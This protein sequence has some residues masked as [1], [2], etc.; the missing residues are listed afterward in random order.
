M[1]VQSILTI[2]LENI[3]G[4]PVRSIENQLH[5][6]LDVSLEEDKCRT[7]M[8]NGCENHNTLRKIAL[9]MLQQQDDN[10]SIKERRKKAGWNDQ[11]LLNIIKNATI[12][13]V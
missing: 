7:K 5:W 10:H 12:K 13:C 2:E 4:P 3:A 9:Q 1:K 6:H 11:Y 8:G